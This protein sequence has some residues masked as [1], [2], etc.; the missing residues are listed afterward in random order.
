M[1]KDPKNKDKENTKPKDS[2]EAGGSSSAACEEVM[3]I[4]D[5]PQGSSSGS[6]SSSAGAARYKALFCHWA[7]IFWFVELHHTFRNF[8]V[9]RSEKIIKIELEPK[10]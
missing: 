6:G 3:E 10:I 9:R 5:E 8:K 2:E 7:T 4:D 1:V